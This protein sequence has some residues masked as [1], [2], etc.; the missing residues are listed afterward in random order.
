MP[1]ESALTRAKNRGKA[2]EGTM[3]A[4][5]TFMAPD[6]SKPPTPTMDP[7]ILEST[8]KALEEA[9]KG[10]Q[11][12]VAEAPPEK[13]KVEKEE[14]DENVFP[15]VQRMRELIRLQNRRKEIETKLKPMS[16]SDLLINDEVSQE[17]VLGKGLTVVFRSISGE[18]D[19]YVTSM[20]GKKAPK[21]ASDQYVSNLMAFYYLICGVVS[22]NGRDLPPHYNP[23][24][25]TVDE[26]AFEEKTK[27]F[28]RKP[29]ALILELSS[30]Y[31]WFT[32]RVRDLWSLDEIKNS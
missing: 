7:A 4:E 27:S 20:V 16:L 13:E 23:N 11:Q 28:K 2:L 3:I 29:A 25:D 24:K 26:T 12:K 32:E 6:L 17:V 1:A 18:E 8:S 30:Q 21:N 14:L 9:R 10:M 22:I 5:R 15:D 31:N 19:F